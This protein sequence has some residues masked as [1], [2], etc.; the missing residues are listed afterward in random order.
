MYS[1]V[2]NTSTY[3][4]PDIDSVLSRAKLNGIE[5]IIVTAGCMK[6]LKEA[7]ELIKDKGI[8]ISFEKILK[9]NYFLVI[10]L[11]LTDSCFC[12]KIIYLQPLEFIQRDVLNLIHTKEVLINI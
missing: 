9:K 6:D 8:S 7:V 3:H 10:V 5:K 12:L 4:P 2:Y 11:P 1:G